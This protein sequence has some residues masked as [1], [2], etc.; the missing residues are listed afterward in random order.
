MNTEIVKIYNA[1]KAMDYAVELADVAGGLAVK[2]Y[3]GNTAICDIA[4]VD[5]IGDNKY[6]EFYDGDACFRISNVKNGVRAI[7]SRMTGYE[8]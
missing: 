1:L 4:V 3:Y 6:L 5:G 2:V 8:N 7:M